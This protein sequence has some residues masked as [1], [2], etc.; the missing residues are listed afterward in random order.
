MMKRVMGVLLALVLLLT[1]VTALA[2]EMTVISREAG[3]GTRSAFVELTGVE[4]KDENGTKV[5]QTW[6]DAIIQNGTAQVITTVQGDVNAIGYISL[7]SLNETVKALKVNGVEAA[8]ERIKDG[9]YALSR[10]FVLAVKGELN[11]TAAD[12]MAGCWRGGPK[13]C[14]GERLRVRRTRPVYG[15]AGC[16]QGGCGRLVL[17]RPADGEACRGVSDGESAGAD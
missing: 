1:S 7:G 16:G 3:S 11:A 14:R 2:A 15:R 6:E 5:D 4:V 8:P 13:D 10:P 9:S 17:C 12:F